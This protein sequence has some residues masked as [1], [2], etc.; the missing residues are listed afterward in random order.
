MRSVA[1]LKK[2]LFASYIDL[3]MYFVI[4]YGIGGIASLFGLYTQSTYTFFS[5]LSV[6]AFLI[7]DIVS[8]SFYGTTIGKKICGLTIE[9]VTSTRPS[10]RTIL[11]R[12]TVGKALS[13]LPLGLGMWWILLNKEKY[14]WHDILTKTRIIDNRLHR[15]SKDK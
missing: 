4:A 8:L 13:L 1:S 14:A 6:F 15:L 10:F 7:Y 12:E 9:T 11:V 5:F 3:I 2:R